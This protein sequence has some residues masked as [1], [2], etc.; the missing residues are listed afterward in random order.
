MWIEMLWE[1]R[2]L[3]ERD[4]TVVTLIEKFILQL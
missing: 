1:E 3:T 4:K 2:V